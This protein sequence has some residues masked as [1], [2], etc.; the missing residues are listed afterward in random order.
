MLVQDVITELARWEGGQ[1]W[2]L[3]REI[4]GELSSLEGQGG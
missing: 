2:T 4:A 3:I 1:V